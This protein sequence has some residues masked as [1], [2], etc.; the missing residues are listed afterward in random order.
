MKNKQTYF[1]VH[2]SKSIVYSVYFICNTP[3]CFHRNEKL[4]TLLIENWF[5]NC[6]GHYKQVGYVNYQVYIWGRKLQKQDA[7]DNLVG[8]Q[9]CCLTYLWFFLKAVIDRHTSYDTKRSSTT[10]GLNHN[11]NALRLRSSNKM[12]LLFC[13]NLNVIKALQPDDHVCVSP[14]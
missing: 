1:I 7:H 6:A 8:Q 14:T 2:C 4:K 13:N 11:G 9:I 10:G 3:I 12:R 5:L